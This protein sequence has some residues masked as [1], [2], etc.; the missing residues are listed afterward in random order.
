MNIDIY[1]LE[2]IW[3]YSETKVCPLSG[4]LSDACEPQN[5]QKEHIFTSAKD[6]M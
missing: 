6:V 1:V 2:T 3:W 4:E 5:A